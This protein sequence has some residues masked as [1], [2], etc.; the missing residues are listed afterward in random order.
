MEALLLASML[1]CADAQWIING[2]NST[3]MPQVDKSEVIIEV[4]QHMPDDCAI[5]R[6]GVRTS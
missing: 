3:D 2:V 5:D 1:T 4:I 6:N